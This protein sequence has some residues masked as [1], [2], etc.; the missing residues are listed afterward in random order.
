MAGN[1]CSFFQ[2]IVF[3]MGPDVGSCIVILMSLG[4]MINELSPQLTSVSDTL[5]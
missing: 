5:C 3:P 2:H 1:Q 4:T